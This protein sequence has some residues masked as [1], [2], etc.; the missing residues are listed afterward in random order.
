M[1][2]VSISGVICGS[3][4]IENESQELSF[5]ISSSTEV[6]CFNLYCASSPIC[7]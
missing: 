1:Q 2:I 6:T 4:Y 3:P 5:Y 7:L